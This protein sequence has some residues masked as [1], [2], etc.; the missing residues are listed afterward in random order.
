MGAFGH[1]AEKEGDELILDEPEVSGGNGAA[2]PPLG[3]PER[4]VD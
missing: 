3:G 1:L 4:D 2:A